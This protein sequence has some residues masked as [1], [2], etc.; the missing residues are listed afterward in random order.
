MFF[1]KGAESHWVF[2]S[3]A[4]YIWNTIGTVS[5]PVDTIQKWLRESFFGLLSDTILLFH[6]Q[7]NKENQKEL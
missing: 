6:L 2:F 3:G 5:G 4:P 7:E 1:F